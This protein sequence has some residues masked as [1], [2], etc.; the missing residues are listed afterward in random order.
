MVNVSQSE[1]M[2][3]FW[4]VQRGVSPNPHILGLGIRKMAENPY[5]LGWHKRRSKDL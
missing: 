4:G 3:G 5:M 2:T 1:K